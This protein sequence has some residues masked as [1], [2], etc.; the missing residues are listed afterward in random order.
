MAERFEQTAGAVRWL[1]LR[2]DDGPVVEL[3]LTVNDATI[4]ARVSAYDL[5]AG[6]ALADMTGAQ[7]RER[8][9]VA[10]R[11]ARLILKATPDPEDLWTALGQAYTQHKT[12][13]TKA[14]N[15]A[16]AAADAAVAAAPEADRAALIRDIA[17][18]TL[19]RLP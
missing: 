16:T 7:L 18:S 5:P 4:D 11:V 12:R 13:W 19:E 14:L 1:R 3:A 10:D 15:A 6:S 8:R 9:G 17:R 2:T